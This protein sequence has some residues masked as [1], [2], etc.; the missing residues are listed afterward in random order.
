MLNRL[1]EEVRT[2]LL[3]TPGITYTLASLELGAPTLR[4]QA[5]ESATNLAG[6]RLVELAANINSELEGIR[7]GS[8]LEG[9]EE[10]PVRIISPDHRRSTLSDLQGKTIGGSPGDTGT[11][12]SALGEMELVPK[13]SIISRRDGLR[14][15]Q[16]L[17]YLDPYTLPAPS[18]EQFQNML[19]DS[20]FVL[21]PGYDML[22]GGEAENSGDAVGNLAAVGIPLMLVMAGAVMLVFNSFRMMLLVMTAGVLSVFFAFFG[23]WLFNLPF[24]FNAIIGSL[25]LFGIAINGTIVA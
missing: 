13:T 5:D 14:T 17:A 8:V 21:P 22:V 15:N 11:P 4:L 24:G 7:A 1:G 10:L 2:V 12:L 16:I 3:Q 25:G 18:L 20:N 19:A 23:V 9:T 6:S